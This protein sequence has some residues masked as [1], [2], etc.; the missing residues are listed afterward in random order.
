MYGDVDSVAHD[1][2]AVGMGFHGAPVVLDGAVIL[3]VLVLRFSLFPTQA[4]GRLSAPESLSMSMAILP[5]YH[6]VAT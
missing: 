5:L 4:P 6:Y 1:G 3:D 2:T